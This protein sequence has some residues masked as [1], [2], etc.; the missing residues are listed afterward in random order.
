[1]QPP[2]GGGVGRRLLGRRG[3]GGDVFAA[4]FGRPNVAD[5]S[6]D[7]I[8]RGVRASARFGVEGIV[9]M[10]L[11]PAGSKATLHLV[12]GITPVTARSGMG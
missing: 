11:E 9:F 1:M 3:A 5:A 8:G 7:G 12:F 6:G 2:Q 10:N 4:G